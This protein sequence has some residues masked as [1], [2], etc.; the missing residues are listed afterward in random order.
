MKS[1]A[2]FQKTF[3][4]DP[5]PQVP[6]DPQFDG[7]TMKTR[8]YR[9]EPATCEQQ[10]GEGDR[11]RS[12]GLLSSWKKP[13]ISRFL[14]RCLNERCLLEAG[15]EI[16]DE[17]SPKEDTIQS[18]SYVQDVELEETKAV[19]SWN[20]TNNLVTLS[21]RRTSPGTFNHLHCYL[22]WY[23][24][25]DLSSRQQNMFK[26]ISISFKCAR[27]RISII[28]FF[29]FPLQAF[30]AAKSIIRPWRISNSWQG[31]R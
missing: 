26:K 19:P 12:R 24:I 31:R 18:I 9:W 11:T 28:L 10:K 13:D 6:Q 22:T 8:L 2:A 20:P 25:L 5:F 7:V 27:S 3:I 14:E 17:D 30:R 4:K 1:A 23:R 16:S 15:L 29:W 21:V